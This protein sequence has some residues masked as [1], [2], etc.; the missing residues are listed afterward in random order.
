[1]D[2]AYPLSLSMP[3]SADK[4][5]NSKIEPW[6]WGL[7][8]DNPYILDSWGKQFHV[9]PRNVF[10]LL[11]KTGEDCA[12]AVQLIRPDRLDDILKGSDDD[13]N[14]YWLTESDIAEC[15]RALQKNPAAWHS[16]HDTSKFS[17]AGAQP[18]TALYSLYFNGQFWGVPSSP[19]PTT[20]ILKP[21]I[22]GLDGHVEN[23]YLCLVL[24]GE[25]GLPTAQSEVHK[26]EDQ[27]ALFV[28]RYDRIWQTFS[29][30][31]RLHQEDLCQARGLSPTKKY[32]NEGGPGC[33]EISETIW[34][35]SKEPLE[36]VRTFARATLLNWIIAGIDAH[37]KNFSML[38]GAGGQARLAPLYDIASELP[39]D[40]DFEKLK[41]A[42]KIGGKYR[43]RDISARHWIRFARDI[44]LPP[45]EVLNMGKAL[46]NTLPEV[47]SEIVSRERAGGFDHPIMTRMGDL[48]GARSRQCA[49]ILDAAG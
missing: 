34:A 5:E 17:L 24:A 27:V 2:G 40:S 47:F 25:L 49:D 33:T 3:L 43:F 8:P 22:V 1:M 10:A 23:E 30:I 42:N 39:Y 37:A 26:Y 28:Q 38:I 7:L 11:A 12:G 6:L 46:A 14:V 45:E 35:H 18:K 13:L 4:Y 32:Q 48:L 29:S 20:H 44:S 36:D 31:P 21:P 41:M 16:A 19:T 9:S 15:L